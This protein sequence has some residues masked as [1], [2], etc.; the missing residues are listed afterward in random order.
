MRRNR[1]QKTERL[2]NVWMPWPGLRVRGSRRS[3]KSKGLHGIPEGHASTSTIESL[4]CCWGVLKKTHAE[5]A[6]PQMAIHCNSCNG[7]N[8]WKIRASFFRGADMLWTHGFNVWPGYWRETASRIAMKSVGRGGLKS[9]KYP[10][11]LCKN[12]TSPP[13]TYHKPNQDRFQPLNWQFHFDMQ[14]I[15]WPQSPTRPLAQ[16]I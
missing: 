14:E 7:L 4:V 15:R 12:L 1:G 3:K 10:L 8:S 6:W 16:Q 2:R 9:I 13:K 11:C 5:R